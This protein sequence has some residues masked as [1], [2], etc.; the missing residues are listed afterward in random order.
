[1]MK[2]YPRQ[3]KAIATKMN[4]ACPAGAA[5]A[6]HDRLPRLAPIIGRVACVNARRSAMI[7]ANCPIS[8]AMF[9][10]FYF[11]PEGSKL[12][13]V[14]ERCATPTETGKKHA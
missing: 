2:E 1:M 7:N 5:T 12:I 3:Q 10:I 4:W 14:G 9:P 6:T 13:A 8:G 11:I